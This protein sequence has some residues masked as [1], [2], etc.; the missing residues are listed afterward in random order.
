MA[1]A[2]EICR[3]HDIHV[4][5]IGRFLDNAYGQEEGNED[6]LQY[7]KNNC[8]MDQL[9]T[10]VFSEVLWWELHDHPKPTCP[11]RHQN[12]DVLAVFR[13]NVIK[14]DDYKQNET[15]T[16]RQLIGDTS[17]KEKWRLLILQ[18]HGVGG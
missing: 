18:R 14:V 2:G 15:V 8:H 11:G 4:G 6:G 7:S 9:P 17:L 10:P 5:A 12:E 1:E 3:W 16:E 13:M